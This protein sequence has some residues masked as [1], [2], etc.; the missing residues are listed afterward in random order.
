M[1]NVFL[2][3]IINW[4][5]YLLILVGTLGW[6]ILPANLLITFIIVLI[7]IPIHW[8]L[9]GGCV[10]TKMERHLLGDDDPNVNF[11]E[12]ELDKVGLAFNAN[13]VWYLLIIGMGLSGTLAFVR[14]HTE[15]A[16]SARGRGL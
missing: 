12:Y 2:A 14:W 8:K 11:I 3:F 5:H 16:Q 9:F 6:A 1:I 13:V 10:V 7:L 4:I 15:R